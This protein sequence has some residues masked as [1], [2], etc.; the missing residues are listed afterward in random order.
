MPINWDTKAPFDL[1]YSSG[2]ERYG[3][4]NTRPQIRLHYHWYPIIQGQ[5][6][7]FAPLLFTV[8]ELNAGESVV[9]GGAGM[10]GPGAGAGGLGGGDTPIRGDR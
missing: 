9:M 1:F 5:A 3:H 7:K 10:K 2:V 4:P 8:R 6:S